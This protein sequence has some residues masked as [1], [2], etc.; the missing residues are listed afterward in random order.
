VCAATNLKVTSKANQLSDIQLLN[1]TA[2]HEVR[3]H[4]CAQAPRHK[5]RVFQASPLIEK[6]QL[7]AQTALSRNAELYDNLPHQNGENVFCVIVTAS[8]GPT[9]SWTVV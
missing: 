7:A 9:A 1:R 4:P 5:L 8:D 2:L 3:Q 6:R